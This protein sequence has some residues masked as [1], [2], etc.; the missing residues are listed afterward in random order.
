MINYNTLI[1][2]AILSSYRASTKMSDKDMK[3]TSCVHLDF[4]ILTSTLMELYRKHGKAVARFLNFSKYLIK[5]KIANA[6]C[7]NNAE[8]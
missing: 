1:P 3:S 7:I 6:R 8:R 4:H 2:S 5:L